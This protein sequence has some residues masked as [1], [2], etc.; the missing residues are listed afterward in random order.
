MKKSP[1]FSIIIPVSKIANLE[2][3]NK[4]LDSLSKQ[5]YKQF[6][7]ILVEES[8][9]N[10]SKSLARNYGAR[11]AKGKYLVHIDTDYLVA[12]TILQRCHRLITQKGAKTITLRESVAPSKN[13]WQKARRLE[14][15]ILS[16]NIHLSTPQIIEKRLFEKIGGFDER[17]DALDDWVLNIKLAKEKVPAYE[18]AS[19]LTYI[20]EPTN[21]FEIIKR[22]YKKGQNLKPFKEKYGTVPQIAIL[23][24]IK[25]YTQN[26]NLINKSPIAFISLIVLKVF[27][28]GA[29][30]LGSLSPDRHPKFTSGLDIYQDK[31]IAKN[32][33]AEQK[34][35]YARFKRYLEVK[36]LLSLLQS[37]NSPDSPKILELGCG[38]GR[39]TEILTDAGFKVPPTD[40]SPAMLAEYKKKMKFFNLPSTTLLKPGKLP[41][42]DNSFDYVVAIRVIWHIK[43]YLMREEFFREA[44]RVARKSAIMDFAIKG[45]GF[46]FISANDYFF[47]QEEIQDL[48]VQNG[49]EI[50][51]SLFLPL[52]R[53]LIKFTKA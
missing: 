42:K 18:I 17:V 14:K 46:N 45:I 50:S 5:D 10:L 52:G 4:C 44:A 13:I 9:T 49:L 19:P 11:K 3:L 31:E 26:I 20:Y 37:P 29:F 24:L 40:I 38:T 2:Y 27:D 53:K 21:I 47:R 23:P 41:Y 25:T 33:D 1:F 48:A 32:F 12:P 15:E 30:F 6:E 16:Q 7:I 51:Q 28:L 36:S 39:I 8:K 35:L 22:R 43:D 34:S